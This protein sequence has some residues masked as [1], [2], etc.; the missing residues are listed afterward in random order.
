MKMAR[1]KKGFKIVHLNIRSLSKH[2]DEVDLNLRGFDI[3]SLSETWLHG[4]IP[5]GMLH[6]NGYHLLRSDRVSSKVSVKKRGG[7]IAYYIGE[8]YDDFLEPLWSISNVTPNLEQFWIEIKRPHN[9]PI[10]IGTC[11]RPPS[12][13]VKKAVDELYV[14]FQ[15][16]EDKPY[17]AE[18]VLLGDFNV[19]YVKT[20][21]SDFKILKDFERKSMLM[22]LI[23]SP[24]RITNIIKSTIDLI[25]TDMS[26]IS[27]SGV[28]PISISD[29]LPIYVIKKKSRPSKSFHVTEGRSY[30]NYNKEQFIELIMMDGRWENY[31]RPGNDPNTLWDIMLNIICTATDKLCPMVK[32]RVRNDTPGWY[33]K[34]IIEQVNL[35]KVFTREF[36]KSNSE[37]NYNN[38]VDCKRKLSKM[39]RRAKQE[40][41]TTSLHENRSN[42]RRFWRIL[43]EDL[44]LNSKKG[45]RQ[46]TRLEVGQNT[47]ITG[48]KVGDYLSDYYATNGKVLAENIPTVLDAEGGRYPDVNTEFD[49]YF[50]PLHIV[51]KLTK[52]IDIYKSSG[53]H[54]IGSELVRDAFLVLNVE[55][56]HLLNE[57]LSQEIFPLKWA[58]GNVTP[59]PKDGDLLDPGNWRPITVLPIPSKIIE[60]AVH[61]QLVNYFEENNYFHNRQHGFRKK[62]ST[63][64]AVHRVLRHIYDAYDLGQSTSC[65]FVDYKKAFETLDHE[66]L[67]QK[68]RKY[69]L[70]T[71]SLAWMNSYLANR[72][73]TVRCNNITSKE[74]TV[75]Y[76]VPQGSILGPTLFI[77]YVND[78]LYTLLNYPSVNIEMYAD[79]TVI[80][81]SDLCPVRASKVNEEIMNRLYKWCMVNKLIINFKKTKHMMIWRYNNILK[82]RDNMFIHVGGAKID[83]VTCYHYL[84]IDL[85]N[86]LTYDKML[87]CMFNKANRKLY[88]LKR[89]RPYIS[90]YVANLV[91]KTHVLPMLDYADFMLDSGKTSKTTRLDNLFWP[92]S[93]TSE[94]LLSF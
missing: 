11:Y 44:G 10:W 59:I 4:A 76:G 52:S 29:H 26:H 37:I 46:C 65:I 50:I 12:G 91:Y 21:T 3:I 40:L 88:M 39:L 87:D 61:Y 23:H 32:L 73:H 54:N 16:L 93:T 13:T 75:S 1:N 25:F 64:T 79:D 74:T 45:N 38:L 77:I 27:E 63:I 19:D 48:S 86:S 9:K 31:W 71:H 68:L 49:F 8:H 18:I 82:E 53:I 94:V 20:S 84:G 62:H 55:L 81:S 80:Y 47:V 92:L 5:D 34:E 43:N 7:G 2:L 28:L 36:R 85:D 15:A 30:K 6:L 78:L 17:V 89:I 58:V 24:T 51:E 66:I 41:I 57:S 67:L 56:T 33:T 72:K 35:K 83:N 70:T 60:R 90:N 69:G 42:P 14:S 22:Q